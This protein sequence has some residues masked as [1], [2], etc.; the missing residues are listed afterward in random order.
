MSASDVTPKRISR[1]V[2]AKQEEKERLIQQ[3]AEREELG[4]EEKTYTCILCGNSTK[5]PKEQFYTT[6]NTE[7]TKSNEGFARIC[8]KCVNKLYNEYK[9][10]FDSAVIA[11]LI[12]CHYL[13]IP[14]IE[15]LAQKVATTKNMASPMGD[16]MKGIAASCY[17]DLTFADYLVDVAEY[18]VDLTS[19]NQKQEKKWDKESLQN[20]AYVK[21][22]VGYDPFQDVS[23]TTD[24]RKFLFNT[25]AGY[26][27]DSSV[28]N[29]SHKLN[30][31]LNIVKQL[32]QLEKINKSINFEL[33]Q[34]QS[35]QRDVVSLV[36]I[37]KTLQ[38]SI[39]RM[40]KDNDISKAN[41]AKGSNTLT[42][43]MKLLS[44]EGFRES[45]VNMF[46]I[47][48]SA[49]MQKLADI[50][51]RAMINAISLEDN[52]YSLI[53]TEQRDELT[54]L[55]GKNKELEEKVRLLTNEV[56][57]K[58]RKGVDNGL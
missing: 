5:R 11:V 58:R 29:D 8:K 16:Y 40:A 43:R 30:T 3:R 27:P 14:Y 37:Q 35:Q 51:A 39:D 34:P 2:L 52:D 48:Q 25:M 10:Q 42:G 31:I 17:Q 23:L 33:T 57:S 4:Q 9:L 19:A 38:S 26:C 18:T 24:D 6:K 12:C 53:I 54:K 20:M 50:S 22:I 55:Y 46:N 41:A 15:R 44:D 49:Q 7:L 47:E 21:N 1:T 36:N 28:A 32:L 13:D 45:E 56:N